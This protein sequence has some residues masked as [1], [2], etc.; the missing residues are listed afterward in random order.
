MPH[1]AGGR[2]AGQKGM[3]W[4]GRDPGGRDLLYRVSLNAIPEVDDAEERER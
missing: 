3:G 4:R 1:G 2:R